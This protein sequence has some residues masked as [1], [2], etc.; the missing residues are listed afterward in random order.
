MR[1]AR[2]QPRIVIAKTLACLC[3]LAAG[4]ALGAAIDRGDPDHVRATQ[5]RA[6]AAEQ[7]ARDRHAQLE[8][9]RAQLQDATAPRARAK[10]AL[11]RLRGVNRRLR[12]DLNEAE[13]LLRQA[14][15]RQ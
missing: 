4:I 11:D 6:T 13:R 14:R 7:T 10:H 5:V 2:E 8:Q 3:L 1:A 9:T 12:R 15:R